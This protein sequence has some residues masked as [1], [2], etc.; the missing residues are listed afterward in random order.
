MAEAD[1]IKLV[2]AFGRARLICVGD[3]MLDHYVTGRVERISPEAPVPVLH[4]DSEERRL[5]GAGNVLRNLHALGAETCFI[6]VT[7]A[8]AAGREITRMVAALGN[9]EAHVL[10]E[11]DRVTSVKTRY[12]ADTQQLLRADRERA[13]PIA[14]ET[15]AD[16]QAQIKAALPHHQLVI[17]SDYAKGVLGNGVAKEIIDVARAAG[18]KVVVDPKGHDYAVYRGASV[19]KPNRRE[20]AEAAGRALA[21]DEAVVAAARELIERHGFG[22]MLV[23]C[24]K[25]GLLVVEGTDVHRLAAEAREVYDV[26]G[27]GDTVVA[28]VGAALAAGASLL[29]AARL[30][31]A[32]AGIVVGKVGTA[33]VH[34]NE[35]AETLVDRDTLKSRKVLPLPLA[36]DHVARWRRNGLKIGFTNG[37]FDLI[38]PGHVSLLGQARAACDR[39]VVGLNSDTS[40]RRLKGP[41]RPV[42]NEAARAAVLASLAPVDLVVVF[43]AE[44]PVELI[45]ELRPDVLVKGAD[46]SRD[47]VVGGDIVESYGGRVLLAEIVPG[48]S[49]TATIAR[50]VR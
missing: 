19:L 12:V 1:L 9:A 38:H 28:V 23:S 21:D 47:Q 31:N 17:L 48:Y 37:C 27:A 26:S 24:G 3:A 4:V 30:A 39:L 42:Q 49:T 20:L 32:A 41:A 15:R 33:V 18:R 14:A 25:D 7:G 36:L 16:L 46:Y 35:L 40:V 44:T 34:A 6:S 45:R 50:A 8:D 2:E 11:R 29:D 10:P 5:G 43:D 13:A 22:A